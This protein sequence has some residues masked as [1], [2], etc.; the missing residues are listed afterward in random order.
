MFINPPRGMTWMRVAGLTR[1]VVL[2]TLAMSFQCA[3]QSRTDSCSRNVYGECIER[4][5]ARSALSP[6]IGSYSGSRQSCMQ[7]NSLHTG[8]T[9]RP[10]FNQSKF[11]RTGTREV[12]GVG[13]HNCDKTK[14]TNR[15]ERANEQTEPNWTIRPTARHALRFAIAPSKCCENLFF[16]TA[17]TVL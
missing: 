1:S 11:V 10:F 7:A 17:A 3:D 15:T 13:Q 14:K 8:D 2:S 9:S 4:D 12:A 6:V 5:C 16:I